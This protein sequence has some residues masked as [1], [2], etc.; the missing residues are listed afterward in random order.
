[1]TREARGRWARRLEEM[2]LILA[3]TDRAEQASWASAAAGGLRDDEREVRNHPLALALARRGLDVASE[4]TLGRVKLA[5]VSRKP[6]AA[7]G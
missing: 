2:A 1:M 3:A 4:V 5:D 7:S 6:S